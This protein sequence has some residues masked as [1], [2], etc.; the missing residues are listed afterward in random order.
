ME[1][2]EDGGIEQGRTGQDRLK[3]DQGVFLLGIGVRRPALYS[4]FSS[5]GKYPG[6]FI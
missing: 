2:D 5:G 1:W 6:V 3:R 4:V